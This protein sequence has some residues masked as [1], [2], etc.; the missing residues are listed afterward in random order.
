MTLNEYQ[1]QA[2]RFIRRDIPLSDSER[3]A[4]FGIASEAGE[5]LDIYKKSYQGHP[6]ETEH[7]IEE[8]GDLMWCAAELCTTLGV[9]LEEVAQTNITKLDIRYPNGFEVSRSLHR[10]TG[11]I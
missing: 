4:L 5:V 1:K 3:H 10:A 7:I 6:V 8:V 9:T 2:A 11:D